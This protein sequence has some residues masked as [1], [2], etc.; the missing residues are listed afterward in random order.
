MIY[1][2]EIHASKKQ[3]VV[4]GE[5]VTKGD[6]ARYRLFVQQFSQVKVLLNT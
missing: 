5:E 2:L 3:E 1:V 4:R 6:T